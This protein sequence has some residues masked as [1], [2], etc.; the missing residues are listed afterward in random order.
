MPGE[1]DSVGDVQPR[2]PAQ[3]L[4][5]VDCLAG[6][7]FDLQLGRK[8][9]IEGDGERPLGGDDHSTARGPL[10]DHV[11]RDELVPFHSHRSLLEEAPD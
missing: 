5:P 1:V 6:N 10:D 7:T 4:N 8:G 3:S 11:L 9:G 2:F